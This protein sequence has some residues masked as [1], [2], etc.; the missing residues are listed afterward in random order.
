MHSQK[1]KIGWFD[2]SHNLHAQGKDQGKPHGSK[3]IHDNFF[4]QTSQYRPVMIF[5]NVQCRAADKIHQMSGK[6]AGKAQKVY[7]KPEASVLNKQGDAV[8]C[9]A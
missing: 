6:Y 8:D 5:Q 2:K 1:Q 7:R 3:G 4:L 9:R